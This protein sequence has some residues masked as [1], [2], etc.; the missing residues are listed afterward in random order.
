MAIGIA[1]SVAALDTQFF[2]QQEHTVS[3]QGAGSTVEDS[4]GNFACEERHSFVDTITEAYRI[5]KA[6]DTD[7]K[8]DVKDYIKGGTIKA[9]G[10]KNY[11]V[12]SLRL[13][14]SNQTK[15]VLTVT[16]EEFFGDTANQAA[17]TPPFGDI[18][19][20]KKAQ[21]IGIIPAAGSSLQRCTAELTLGGLDRTDAATGGSFV[22]TDL[23]GGRA[24]S[25]A[26]LVA[27]TGAPT[28]AADTAND[29]ELEQNASL[30]ERPKEH[31]KSTVRVYTIVDPD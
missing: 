9:S 3:P 26:E 29:W 30:E 2:A 24:T 16:L 15:P 27:C 28:A 14:T 20:I 22:T 7:G 13:E 11:A 12:S 1:T 6:D 8:I 25:E 19:P 18:A 4:N 31:Q 17:Y 23:F 5:I 21:A 10:G